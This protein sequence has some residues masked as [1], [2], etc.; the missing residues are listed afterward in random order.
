MTRILLINP[1]SPYLEN[2]AAYPPMGLLYLAAVLEDLGCHTDIADLTGGRP[3]PPTGGYD[4]A[5]ITCVTPNVPQVERLIPQIDCPVMVGGPH[6]TF[7]PTD[8]IDR[9]RDGDCIV[10]G[11]AETA[12]PRIV[13]DLTTGQLGPDYLCGLPEP[14][15]IPLPHRT[16][17]DLHRY[18]PGGDACT[19]V[20]TSR[21]CPYR[22]AFCSKLAGTTYRRF[23]VDRVIREVTVCKDLGFSKI[24]FGDDNM[25]VNPAYLSTLLTALEP[26][27]IAF[28]LNMDS[29]RITPDLLAQAHAAGCTEISMGIE[30]GSQRFLDAMQKQARVDTNA[31]AIRQV[32]DA[33]MLAKAYFMVNFPGETAETVEETLRFAEAARPDRWLLSAFAP[34]PGS[35][36]WLNPDRYGITAVSKTWGDYYL[37]G[38]DGR[39]APCFETRALPHD[40]QIA[41]HDRLLH[42][43]REV[44]A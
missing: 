12:L 38:K 13:A 4:L 5:G 7:L 32:Q 33:G 24:V 2:D 22:C 11:E 43:L 39:F 16:K 42:G 31:E 10:R 21:G 14:D 3:L 44:C 41:F 15:Q 23:S 18:R 35:A 29:R 34:L 20:Y 28:R 37:V 6:P 1:P 40:R 9:I 36:V 25:N 19:P 17:I 27:D 26:L 8:M 30:S